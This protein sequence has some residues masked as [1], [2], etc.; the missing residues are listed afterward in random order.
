LKNSDRKTAERQNVNRRT[1]DRRQAHKPDIETS[2][3]TARFYDQLVFIGTCGLY[4]RLLKVVIEA[5]DIQPE[6][7]I[8]DMGAGTGKNALL[9]HRHLQ[10]GSITSLEIGGEM[11]KQFRQKCGRYSNIFLENLRIDEPLP[12]REQFDKVFISYV[13]HGFKGEDREVILRNAYQALKYGGKLLIFDWNKF[14][15]QE[16]GPIMRFFMHH[17]E[18]EPAIGFIRQDLSK[19]LSHIGF[20]N[21]G[22]TLYFRNRIRLLS[23]VK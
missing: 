3:I 7:R 11:R 4:H 12:F 23:C 5:M 1:A 8:L 10:G 6:D 18:C 15:L 2:G 9:M 13:L 16:S 20:E 21:M 19:M 14:E 17:I 22:S